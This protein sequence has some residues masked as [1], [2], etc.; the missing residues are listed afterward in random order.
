MLGRTR[1]G[2]IEGGGTPEHMMDIR[3]F[4]DLGDPDLRSAWGKLEDAGACPH[5]FVSYPWVSVWSRQFA[6]DGSPMIIVGYEGPDPVGLAPLFAS[7]GGAV[8]F[9]V[10]FL[11]PRG[12]FLLLGEQ[13]HPLVPASLRFLR[14]QGLRPVFRS[15]PR[16]SAS[17]E[18]LVRHARSAGFYTSS[19]SGRVAP[20][21]DITTTW[22]E[23]RATAPRKW[24]GKRERESRKLERTGDVRV[25]GGLDAA[26]DVGDLVAVFADLEARSWKEQQGTSI[27]GRGLEAFYKGLC[28]TLDE[29]GMF[30]PYWLE[31]DGR[32]IAFLLGAVYRGTYFALKTSYDEAY[33]RLS[34]G[35]CL[36]YRA[37]QTMFEDGL[38]QVDFLGEQAKW[39]NEWA[40][41]RREHA[42]VTLYPA[43]P[44]G[45]AAY[46]RDAW[47][48][49]LARRIGKRS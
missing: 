11:S 42:T 18:L 36:F 30:R 9:P 29:A 14:E 28:R 46:A 31:L 5:I 17:F 49:P 26:M 13:A 16:E 43:R 1:A 24:T 34:P 20:Y 15:V 12:E 38:S 35:A 27:R 39:K 10:N 40:T 33:S 47:L 21:L 3:V 44:A 32:M 37:I 8:G 22:E 6:A 7:K 19:R 45:L 41:G 48:K 2:A 4:S 25:V 23:F